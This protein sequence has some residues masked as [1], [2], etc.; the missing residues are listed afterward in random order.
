MF[1]GCCGNQSFFCQGWGG[2]SPSKLVEAFFRSPLA[3]SCVDEWPPHPFWKEEL[4]FGLKGYVRTTW[5][6]GRIRRAAR[7]HHCSSDRSLLPLS[8]VLWVRH[9]G[10]IAVAIRVFFL[11]LCTSSGL[12]ALLQLPSK[13]S[14]SCALKSGLR[15]LLQMPSK[16]SFGCALRQV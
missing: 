16:P 1:R 15:A 6:S 13:S 4:G 9:E 11:Q 14:F 7:M 10:T 5:W 12:R 2:R 8:A 3:R